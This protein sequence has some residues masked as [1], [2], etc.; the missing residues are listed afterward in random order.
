LLCQC[1][2]HSGLMHLM[3][4]SAGPARLHFGAGTRTLGEGH[5][6]VPSYLPLA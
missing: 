1:K 2:K 4:T 5:G 6:A 3:V